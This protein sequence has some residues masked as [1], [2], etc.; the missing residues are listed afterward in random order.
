M[1]ET[2]DIN[3][4]SFVFSV[5]SLGLYMGAV[6]IKARRECGDSQ[7][8]EITSICEPPDMGAGN[9]MLSQLLLS[10]LCIFLP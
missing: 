2:C 7:E 5:S 1:H 3:F 6:A 8:I 10:S 4:K 9:R